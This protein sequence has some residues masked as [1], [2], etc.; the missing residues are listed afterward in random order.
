MENSALEPHGT[1]VAAVQL[2]E[3]KRF[4]LLCQV[5]MTKQLLSPARDPS[6]L[7]ICT[8]RVTSHAGSLLLL[9]YL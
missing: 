1:S 9:T 2:S 8:T 6:S 4:L 3:A 5:R 7:I